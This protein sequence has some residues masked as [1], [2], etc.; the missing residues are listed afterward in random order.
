VN[1]K[2]HIL[3]NRLSYDRG[4]ERLHSFSFI[5]QSSNIMSLVPKFNAL[6]SNKS[7]AMLVI[8]GKFVF[9]HAMKQYG[10]MEL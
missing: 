3:K 1:A 9:V 6:F 2:G 10:R 7:N 5:K 8:K 4:G